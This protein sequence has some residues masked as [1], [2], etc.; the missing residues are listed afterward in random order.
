MLDTQDGWHR[1]TTGDH[2]AIQYGSS[3]SNKIPTWDRAKEIH[4]FLGQFATGSVKHGKDVQTANLSDVQQGE[5]WNGLTQQG[6]DP[7]PL[8]ATSVSFTMPPEY[9]GLF[10]IC[11]SVAAVFALLCLDASLAHTDLTDGYEI[12]QAMKIGWTAFAKRKQA[13]NDIEEGF[14]CN[15]AAAWMTLRDIDN[16]RPNAGLETRMRKVADLAGRMYDAL[17]PTKIR[18]PSDDPH[19]VK[20]AKIGGTIERLLPSEQAKLAIKGTADLQAMKVL[21]KTAQEF[22]MKGTRTTSRGPMVLTKDESSSMHDEPNTKGRHTWATASAIALARI[23]WDENR[24][25]K[26]VHFSSSTV[27]AELPKGDQRAMFE[28]ARTFL[29]GGTNIA[30]ALWRAL[31]QVGDLE[32]AGLKGADVVLITDGNDYNDRTAVLAEF[33]TRGVKLHTVGIGID[34]QPTSDIRSTAETYVFAHDAALH[35]NTS[36]IDML[37]PL[38]GAALDNSGADDDRDWN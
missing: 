16:L 26:M 36:A 23:A 33:A 8:L 1:P 14:G 25:V 24:A 32:A 30:S 29:A 10:V 20:G 21:K 34:I 31:E 15:M 35:S 27:V 5:I 18:T 17:K 9:A 22:S 3:Y 12:R 2:M 38:V 6:K 37:E 13:A 7:A 19:E 28:M 4:A 11:D